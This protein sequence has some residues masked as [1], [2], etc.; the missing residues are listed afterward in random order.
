MIR[1]ALKEDP[2]LVYFGSEEQT[3]ISW[4]EV[5]CEI[6]DVASKP[7][8][9]VCQFNLI[10]ISCKWQKNNINRHTEISTYHFMKIQV[11]IA[12]AF[13][14]HS[15]YMKLFDFNIGILLES[16]T[17]DKLRTEALSIGMLNS[18]PCEGSSGS[19]GSGQFEKISL[20]NI[21]SAFAILL[22]G[23]GMD[24]SK[25]FFRINVHDT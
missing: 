3:T 21:L 6:V 24:I 12:W 16:G 10:A 18:K 5:P 4:P 23:I 7:Y 14:K 9:E 22:S 8:F 13:E 25:H 11:S 19:D 2:K 20:K 17:V 15:P 1:K